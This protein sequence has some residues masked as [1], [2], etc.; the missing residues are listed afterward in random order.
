MQLA[1]DKHR[2][3]T[4]NFENRILSVITGS[5]HPLSRLTTAKLEFKYSRKSRNNIL[6]PK[7]DSH[8]ISGKQSLSHGYQSF[9]KSPVKSSQMMMYQTGKCCL[10]QK[11]SHFFHQAFLVFNTEAAQST[12]QTGLA[13]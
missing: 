3:L 9:R 7:R 8:L 1:K 4:L 12:A 13:L 6:F 5:F 11:M 2:F 10:I